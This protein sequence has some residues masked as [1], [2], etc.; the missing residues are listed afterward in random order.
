[1]ELAGLGFSG[2]AVEF[3]EDRL[4]RVRRNSYVLHKLSVEIEPQIYSEKLSK[5]L[6]WVHREHK[7]R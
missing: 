5:A 2:L 1:M 6:S 7:S 4:S 3:E